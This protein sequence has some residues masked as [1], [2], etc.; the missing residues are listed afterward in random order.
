VSNYLIELKNEKKFSISLDERKE[1]RLGHIKQ[2]RL[3][4]QKNETDSKWLIPPK[5]NANPKNIVA[6]YNDFKHLDKFKFYERKVE[7]IT[8]NMYVL[9]DRDKNKILQY[10]FVEDGKIKY[11]TLFVKS[12]DGSFFGY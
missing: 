7:S 6:K 9:L 4:M 3:E 12:E 11:F 1:I 8:K 5:T 10:F 2:I